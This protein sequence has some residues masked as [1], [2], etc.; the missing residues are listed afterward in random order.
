[1]ELA[2]TVKERLGS[3]GMVTVSLEPAGTGRE[4]GRGRGTEAVS[5]SWVKEWLRRFVR[6]WVRGCVGER[7]RK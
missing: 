7:A 5:G 6:E 3:K 1:M 2:T 4:R